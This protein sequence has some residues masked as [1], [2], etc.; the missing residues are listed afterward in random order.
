MVD[1][2]SMMVFVADIDR[3]QNLINNSIC[4]ERYYYLSLFV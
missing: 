2:R 4:S 1:E 3:L